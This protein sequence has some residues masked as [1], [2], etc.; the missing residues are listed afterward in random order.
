VP[1]V[2]SAKPSSTN[3]N[4]LLT[5]PQSDAE[6]RPGDGIKIDLRDVILATDD[7]TIEE[8]EVPQWQVTVGVKTMSGYR[9]AQMMKRASDP[10]T[11]IVD[12]EHLYPE[13]VIACCV[14]PETHEP[15][16]RENDRDAL[17]T[18]AGA[19]LELIAGAGLRVSGL[20]KTAEKKLGKD[21]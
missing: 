1:I 19:A 12:F 13:I 21:S 10:E 14:D 16:F 17:N 4:P 5:A 6:G 15:L 11:G 9:R 7:I 3:A 2:A 18:K 20:D 8:I